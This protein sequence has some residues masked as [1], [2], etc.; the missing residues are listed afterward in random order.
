MKR[1]TVE[2]KKPKSEECLSGAVIIQTF[3]SP[4]ERALFVKEW[5]S[6]GFQVLKYQEYEIPKVDNKSHKVDKPSSES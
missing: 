5:L 4:E 2:M 3:H 1:Y 6:K